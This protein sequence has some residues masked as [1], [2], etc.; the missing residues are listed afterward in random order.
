[1]EKPFL[2]TSANDMLHL[3]LLVMETLTSVTLY[4]NLSSET[5]PVSE[6]YSFC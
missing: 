6:I 4:L 2:Q 5:G 3:E 1:M